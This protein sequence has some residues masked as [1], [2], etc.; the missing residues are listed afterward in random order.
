MYYFDQLAK[1]ALKKT[2]SGISESVLLVAGEGLE[3]PTFG[4]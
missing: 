3:P 1:L 4:L 2:D